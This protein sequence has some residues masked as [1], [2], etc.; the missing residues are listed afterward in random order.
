LGKYNEPEN[1]ELTP[2]EIIQREIVLKEWINTQ[3]KGEEGFTPLHFAAFH[4]NLELIKF[5]IEKGANIEAK[6]KQDINMMH[7]AA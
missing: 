2:N 1:G 7:V 3:S 6:N 4:G 5:L